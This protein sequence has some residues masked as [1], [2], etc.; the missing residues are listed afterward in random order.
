MVYHP[1]DSAD[2]HAGTATFNGFM[3]FNGEIE[4]KGNGSIVFQSTGT[5]GKQGAIC[6]W[7]SDLK[8][9]T[10]DLIGLKMTG[11]YKA[12]GMSGGKVSVEIEA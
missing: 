7:E 9:G 1:N 6:K 4:G 11:G 3:Y 10:G 8:T 5:F 12:M 2:V